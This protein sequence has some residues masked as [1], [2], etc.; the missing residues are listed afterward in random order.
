MEDAAIATAVV[1]SIAG[2]MAAWGMWDSWLKHRH[3]G[4]RAKRED[5]GRLER[6]N[7]DLNEQVAMLEDRMAVLERIATDPATRTAA[8][9]E[10]LR[11]RA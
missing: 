11:E 8:E 2:P 4:K 6:E 3:G 10:T 7:R 5:G 1:L 9:I